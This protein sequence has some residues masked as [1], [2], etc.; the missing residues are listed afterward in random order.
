[1]VGPPG[2]GKVD[3]GAAPAL[4]PAAAHRR[5]ELLDVSMI[6]SVAGDL[7]GGKL[8]D[9]RPFRAPHHSASMAAMVGGG[10]RVQPGEVSLAHNGV[11]F[12][13]ELP[14]IHAAGAR[15]AAPAARNRRM[16]HRP[17]QSPRFLSGPHPAGRGDEP[18]PLRHGRRAGP[19]LRARTALRRPTT[20]R[21][22][23][24]RCSTASIC[25]SRC[26]RSCRAT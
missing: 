11:L 5:R 19:R 3:A 1:M 18:V 17:R 7:A 16:R 26:R 25:A 2:A 21:A 12:L 13:D 4:D 8:S 14:G 6:H 15:C 20:R 9:R 23:P 10:L 22:F 24:A